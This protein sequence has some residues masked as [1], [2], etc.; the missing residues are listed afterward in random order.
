MMMTPEVVFLQSRC[1][2]GQSGESQVVRGTLFLL[3]TPLQANLPLS[4][5][6]KV[7]LQTLWKESQRPCFYVVEERSAFFRRWRQWGIDRP[8]D[9]EVLS[10]NEHH[11]NEHL[12]ELGKHLLQGHHLVLC[13][14]GG[15]PAYCDPGIKLIQ[16]CYQH[17]IR[18]HLFPMESSILAAFIYAAFDDEHME[19]FGFL[20]HKDEH[21][22]KSLFWK[23]FQSSHPCIVMD[24]PYR[25]MRTLED[26]EKYTQEYVQQKK[27]KIN[28]SLSLDLFSPEEM[29]M[30]GTPF[31]LLKQVEQLENKKRYFVLVLLATDSQPMRSHEKARPITSSGRT[32]QSR[33][34]F[35]RPKGANRQR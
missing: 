10:L 22:R 33:S 3:P 27:I 28:C 24:T 21:L 35:S 34:P 26:L 4:S 14:D 2:W 1:Q 5:F 6:S 18:V 12:N 19:C 11:G 13:S 25:L 7:L 20:P 29:V 9:H 8:Q 15:M 16:W 30:R 17:Q 32:S 23:I 31:E